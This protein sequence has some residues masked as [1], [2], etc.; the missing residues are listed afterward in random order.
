MKTITTETIGCDLGDKSSSICVLSVDGEVVLERTIRSDPTSF[1]KFFGARAPGRVVI[2][3]GGHSRWVSEL[4]KRLA[5][6]VL[7]ANPRRLPVLTASISKNDR[8]DARL[9]AQL[10]RADPRLLSPVTH[11]SA[12]AQ[13]DLSVLKM[14]ES[15]VGVRTRIINSI[16]GQMKAFG[17]RVP[18]CEPETFAKTAKP[19]I[20]EILVPALQPCLKLLEVTDEQIRAFDRAIK[21][22]E[23]KHPQTARLQQVH[24]VGPI[25]ALAFVLTMDDP[26]KFAKSR[27]VGAYFG[28]RPRQDQ[29]GEDDKQ[30]RITK[31]GDGFVRHLLVN[32]AHVVLQ[33][34]FAKPSDLRDFGM[35][36]AAR[37]GKSAKKRAVVAVARKLAVLLHRLWVSGTDYVPV[38]YR[39]SAAR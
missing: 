3:V 20:P 12:D 4:L 7:I 29:S 19:L 27:V 10:G 23:A 15:L 1:G 21:V 34:R 24:G 14:R 11:R 26:D 25:T 13:A 33:Q 18:R 37:G 8:N 17:L 2:E 36:I 35:R 5:W 32:A 38:G 30:L 28:L 31:A 16:R 9:L 39:R 22:L 6:D